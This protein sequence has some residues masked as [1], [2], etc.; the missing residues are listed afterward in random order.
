MTLLFGS[1][2]ANAILQKDI[3]FRAREALPL[4]VFVFSV[5][6]EVRGE[7]AIEARDEEEARTLLPERLADFSETNVV[8][9]EAYSMHVLDI[10]EEA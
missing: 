4:R 1:E 10:V 8:S 2:E 6:A 7:I 9:F 3:E 5:N